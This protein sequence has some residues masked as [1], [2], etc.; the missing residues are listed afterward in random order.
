MRL[1]TP[2][3]G[4][5]VTSALAAPAVLST[6]AHA[7]TTIS[8]YGELHYNNLSS[9]SAE[10]KEIDFHRFVLEFGHDFTDSIRFFSDEELN[11]IVDRLLGA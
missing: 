7:E 11:A 3:L 1:S 10:K 4:T 9:D 8:G 6:S 2:L 5:L